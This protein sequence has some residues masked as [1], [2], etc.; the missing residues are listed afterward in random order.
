M[1]DQTL[2]YAYLFNQIVSFIYK[3]LFWESKIYHLQTF[4]VKVKI[5][6]RHSYVRSFIFYLAQ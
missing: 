5:F 6:K 4:L 2:I 3:V 1:S